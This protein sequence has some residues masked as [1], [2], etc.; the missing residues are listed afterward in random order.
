MYQQD[1]NLVV[2]DAGR[3]IYRSG[4]SSGTTTRID[5]EGDLYVGYRKIADC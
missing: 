5:D 2:I 3:P 4:I 1:G